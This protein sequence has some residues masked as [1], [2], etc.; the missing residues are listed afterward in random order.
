MYQSH[1]LGLVVHATVELDD[2]FREEL[3]PQRDGRLA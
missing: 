2:V 3:G 1:V